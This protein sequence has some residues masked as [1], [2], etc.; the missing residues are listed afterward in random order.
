MEKI[1][2][3]NTWV[4]RDIRLLQSRLNSNSIGKT[5]NI[6]NKI[7]G[8]PLFVSSPLM[9][10]WGISDYEDNKKYSIALN[11]PREDDV[12]YSSQTEL[13][14]TKMKEFETVLIEAVM[15]RSEDLFG[16]A[17]GLD[18]IK[19]MFVP[20]VKY[21]KMKDSQKK[22]FNKPP[23]IRA[24]VTNYDN[25]WDK[26]EIYDDKSRIIFPNDDIESNGSPLTLVPSRSD[27]AA[28]FHVSQ[29]WTINKQ[30]GCTFRLVH[31]LVCQ[32][33]EEV[34]GVCPFALTSA[35]GTATV[36]SDDDENAVMVT[37][38]K[39]NKKS[40]TEAENGQGP[41][42][43]VSVA[44]SASA[45]ASASVSASK[46]K[47]EKE[48]AVPAKQTSNSKAVVAKSTSNA[49]KEN[50]DDNKSKT[51]TKDRKTQSTE[52]ES[53]GQ[54]DGED[55]D[56]DEDEDEEEDEEEEEEEKVAKPVRASAPAPAPTP[57]PAPVPITKTTKRK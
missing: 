49:K 23:S 33:Q 10:S 18:F 48:T 44:A 14:L 1:Q 29:I 8:Q 5:I 40:N 30:W 50:T 11:F 56:E 6:A 13:F 4:P 43:T 21:S 38:T 31:C 22:D 35:L 3:T 46:L 53:D 34:Y 32:K 45:S 51:Q 20:I 27:V 28:V 42:S 55:V 7:S 15:E 16:E 37:M 9:M 17:Y 52:P 12:L 47:T 36:D 2:N 26:L 25:N 24:K 39:S 54:E 57:T 19:N 41:S